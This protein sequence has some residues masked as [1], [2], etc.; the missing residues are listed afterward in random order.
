M[1]GSTYLKAVLGAE[2]LEPRQRSRTEAIADL[3][4]HIEGCGE[5]MG[6][7]YVRFIEK[8]YIE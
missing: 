8:L 3:H 5:K 6:N 2:E 7:A 4:G 1:T